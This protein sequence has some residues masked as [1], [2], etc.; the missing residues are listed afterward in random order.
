MNNV[1]YTVIDDYLDKADH[2]KIVDSLCTLSTHSRS[3]QIKKVY[4][5]Y[6]RVLPPDKIAKEAEAYNFMFAQTF[7]DRDNS[8]AI[9]NSMEDLYGLR[10]L[11]TKINPLAIFRIKANMYPRADKVVMHGFHADYVVTNAMP[12]NL[13]NKMKTMVYCVNTNNGKVVF[14]NGVKIDSIANRAII[15]NTDTQHSGTTCTDEFVR[16]VI[17]IN[18]ISINDL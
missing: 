3:Q 1:E 11:I 8:A 17:N 16:C 13:I 9:L 18:Y 10:A 6:S 14:E 15:F 5:S 2:L 12:H 7:G 4:W